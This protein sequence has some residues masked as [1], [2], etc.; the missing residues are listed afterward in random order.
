VPII[1]TPMERRIYRNDGTLVDSNRAHALA[2]MDVATDLGVQVIDLN[3][4]CHQTYQA[5]GA[6]NTY[7]LHYYNFDLH[8]IDITHFSPLGAR[9]YAKE[10]A[11]GLSQIPELA[12]HVVP[13]PACAFAVAGLLPLLLRRRRNAV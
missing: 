2:A 10:V 5:L 1:V 8:S 7:A 9:M 11:R 13:E 4:F 3:T 12:V 6:P